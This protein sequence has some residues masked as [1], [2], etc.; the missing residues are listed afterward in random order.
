MVDT[1]NFGLKLKIENGCLAVYL[2]GIEGTNEW[3]IGQDQISLA[4]LGQAISASQNTVASE[5]VVVIDANPDKKKKKT[6]KVQD[7][8][9]KVTAKAERAKKVKK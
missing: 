2:T 1:M 9:P 4:E 6:S 8:M 5:D 3:V 7:S